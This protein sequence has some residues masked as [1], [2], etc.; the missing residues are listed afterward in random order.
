MERYQ[1]VKLIQNYRIDFIVLILFLLF[2]GFLRLWNLSVPSFWV[3]EVNT[4]FAADSLT[5]TGSPT[6]PSGM[7]YDRAFLHT[8]TVALFYH[9]L[10]LVKQ[11]LGCLLLFLDFFQLLWPILWVEKSFP[12]K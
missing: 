9:F 1:N 7:I 4:V 2:G 5:K 3:D 6:L 11:L 12:V 8:Y 10:A